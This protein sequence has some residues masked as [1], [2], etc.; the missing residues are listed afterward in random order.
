MF[1]IMTRANAPPTTEPRS[2]FPGRHLFGGWAH[3]LRTRLGAA[4]RAHERRRMFEAVGA[5]VL[6]DAGLPPDT[7]TGLSG[8]DPDL[9]F[10]MQPGFGRR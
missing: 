6:R 9:P 2:A 3:A 5:D 8:W 10:F 4:A 1:T 7:A